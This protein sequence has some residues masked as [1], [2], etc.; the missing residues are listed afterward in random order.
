M[1]SNLNLT[2]TNCNNVYKTFQSSTEQFIIK[3]YKYITEVKP[4]ASSCSY[5]HE[6]HAE[7]GSNDTTI[8]GLDMVE[9]M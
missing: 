1:K 6:H 5:H 4:T 2:I 7:E 9:T 8:F 3:Q